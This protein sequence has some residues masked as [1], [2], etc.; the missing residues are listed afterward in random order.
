M[1]T[2]R[3]GQAPDMLDRKGFHERFVIRFVDPAFDSQREAIARLENIA[4]EATG[5]AARRRTPARPAR[6]RRSGLRTV[7]RL[8]RDRAAGRARPLGQ[9]REPSRVLMICGIAAQRR[10]LPRR[11]VEDLPAGELAREPSSSRSRSTCST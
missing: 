7:G 8:A 4:L 6:I 1:T 2:I 9:P 10:H 3:K 11:D 5:K